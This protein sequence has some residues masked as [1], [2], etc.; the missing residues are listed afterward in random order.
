MIERLFSIQSEIAEAERKVAEVKYNKPS[1]TPKDLRDLEFEMLFL[2]HL[3]EL[4]AEIESASK[5]LNEKVMDIEDDIV[6]FGNH[7]NDLP[8]DATTR[9]IKSMWRRLSLVGNV[10]ESNCLER[11]KRDED[12]FTFFVQ[13]QRFLQ[14]LKK[15]VSF[16]KAKKEK[17]RQRKAYQDLISDDKQVTLPLGLPF[18]SL[19]AINALFRPPRTW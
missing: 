4:K 11:A 13:L 2:T 19:F 16:V 7:D 3:E 1:P 6:F 5:R 8:E 9:E 18:F 12:R 15:A 17:D 10:S 14:D